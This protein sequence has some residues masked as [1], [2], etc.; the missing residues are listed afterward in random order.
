MII[1]HKHKFIF[2]CNGKT[3]TTSIERGLQ[4]LDESVDMNNGAAGLWDNKHMPAAAARA[5]LPEAV[6][7]HYF[8]FAFVR[9]PYDWCVS[10]F[11][12]NFRSRLSVRKML[13][14]PGLAAGWLRAHWDNRSRRAKRVL[15]ES[16]IHFLFAHLRRYRGLPFAGSLYQSGYVHDADG[17]LIVDFVGKFESLE[18]DVSKV[19]EKLGIFFDLPHLNATDHPKYTEFLTPSAMDAVSTLWEPDFLNFGYPLH[20]QGLS[21]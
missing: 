2:I 16:D 3:G 17:R 15:D 9:N 13:R 4:G 8:K 10:Q 7:Q 20:R 21:G 11:K 12:H 14:H 6:W 19:Q 18:S 1:S 5:F